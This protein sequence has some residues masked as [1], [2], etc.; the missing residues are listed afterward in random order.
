LRKAVRHE[1]RGR[2]AEKGS[3]GTHQHLTLELIEAEKKKGS[4]GSEFIIHLQYLPEPAGIGVFVLKI[5]TK[6]ANNL[7]E[8]K[9]TTGRLG[10]NNGQAWVA[11]EK[12]P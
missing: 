11:G 12:A 4:W 2:R 1:K 7:A 8:W 10:K 6:E 5:P 9:M 3:F